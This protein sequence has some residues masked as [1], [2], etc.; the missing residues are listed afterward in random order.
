MSDQITSTATADMK[1]SFDAKRTIIKI[2][3]KKVVKPP[4]HAAYGNV[5]VDVIFPWSR[6]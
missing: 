5:D 3:S 2:N 4:S 6:I 1:D